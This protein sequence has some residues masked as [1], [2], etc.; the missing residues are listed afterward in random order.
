M[1]EVVTP[2]FPSPD[3]NQTTN[4]PEDRAVDSRERLQAGM[5]HPEVEMAQGLAIDNHRPIVGPG[6]LEQLAIAGVGT[7]ILVAVALRFLVFN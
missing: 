4:R 7:L 6:R 5:R 2:H 3:P 1:N